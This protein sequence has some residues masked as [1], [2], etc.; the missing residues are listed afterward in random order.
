[1]QI[2]QRNSMWN[3]S[4]FPIDLFHLNNELVFKEWKKTL[5]IFANTYQMFFYNTCHVK[6]SRKSSFTALHSTLSIGLTGNLSIWSKVQKCFVAWSL[7][8][9]ST[10]NVLA[11]KKTSVYHAFL[12]SIYAYAILLWTMS[13]EGEIFICLSIITYPFQGKALCHS[14]MIFQHHTRIF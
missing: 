10:L 9:K 1:M 4:K 3:I 14:H 11:E 13:K 2:G 12:S 8:L 6:S 7:A 5:V